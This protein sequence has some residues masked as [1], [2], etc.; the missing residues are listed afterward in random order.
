M[1]VISVVPEFGVSQLRKDGEDAAVQT[2]A[3]ETLTNGSSS[4][5]PERDVLDDT[6]ALDRQ[7]LWIA[8]IHNRWQVKE[9]CRLIRKC[10]LDELV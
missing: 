5:M 1:L 6:R 8:Q 7:E 4:F 10:K 9:L 3:L 2:W